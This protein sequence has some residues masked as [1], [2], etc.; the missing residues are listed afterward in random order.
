[1]IDIC[2]VKRMLSEKYKICN[3]KSKLCITQN[4]EVEFLEDEIVIMCWN[5]E[6]IYF[7][8]DYRSEQ[9]MFEIIDSFIETLLY[10]PVK[11]KEYYYKNILYQRTLN[12]QDGKGTW[13]KIGSSKKFVIIFKRKNMIKS[14]DLQEFVSA[15][16]VLFAI[17]D[18]IGSIPVFINLRKRGKTIN[19]KKA[20]FLALIVFI[21]FFYGGEA[22]LLL[23]GVDLSSFAIAGS[24]IIF[25]IA[26]ELILDIEIFKDQPESPKDATFVPVVFPLIAGAGALTTLLS[27]RSQFADINI[28]LAIFCNIIVVYFILKAAKRLEKILKP[29]VII[30]FQK[31]FGI[32]LL[33]I[34]VKLFTAS[35]THMIKTFS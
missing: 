24:L 7:S 26:L 21:I 2:V 11:I 5:F 22:F 9:E 14:F 23:F 18:V 19:A 16:F 30:I 8:F 10:R 27:L 29:G 17:I 3:N 15:F 1:M 25:V 12:Q 4:I 34:S 33:A 6:Y 13:K 31:F 28:L 32:I 20:A 35:L